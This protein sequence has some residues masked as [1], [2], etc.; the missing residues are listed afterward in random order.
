[1]DTNPVTVVHNAD[2]HRYE[3]ELDGETAVLE[4]RDAN[5]VRYYTHTRVPSAFEGRGIGSKLARFALD[6]AQAQH[7]TVV[8]ECPFVRTYIEKHAEYQ[9]LVQPMAGT[10]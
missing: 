2:K 1:M 9:P 3:V 8:P 10:E 6:E 4:Y 5:G 7:L